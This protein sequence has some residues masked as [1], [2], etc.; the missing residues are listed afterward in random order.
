MGFKGGRIDVANTR[1]ESFRL[2]GLFGLCKIAILTGHNPSPMPF[3]CR[4]SSD[5]RAKEIMQ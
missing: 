5:A 4:G 1:V 2:L 3:G